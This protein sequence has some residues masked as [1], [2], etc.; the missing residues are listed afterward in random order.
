MATINLTFNTSAGQDAKLAKV[1]A[2]VNAE[3]TSA[4]EAEFA[5]IEEYFEWVLIEAV[6]SYVKRQ[7]EVDEETLVSK[8]NAADPSVQAQVDAL[9]P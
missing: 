8:Y 5:T 3:R 7:D 1:L 2:R 9:L 4:E 6:K